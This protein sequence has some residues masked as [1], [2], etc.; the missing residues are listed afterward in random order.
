MSFALSAQHKDPEA[1]GELRKTLELKP[2][3]YEADLNLGILLLRNQRPAEA[4]SVLK[5]AAGAKPKEFR[6]NY[7]CGDALLATGD[8]EGAAHYYEA[9]GGADPKSAAAQLGLAHALLKAGKLAEAAPH[10]RAAAALDPQYRDG[11]LELAAA[12]E[13]SK[14]P[15][16]A[17]AIYREFPENVAARERMGALQVE[18]KDYTS[19][20]PN[21]EQ[22]VRTSPTPANRL[23]LADAYRM[24]GDHGKE[25]EQLQLAAAAEP[26]NFDL[27]MILGRALR[28]ERKLIPAAD[29]FA[30]ATRL[31]PDDVKAWNELAAAL[32]IGERYAEGLAALD[33]V[34]ALGKEL[35]GDFYLRAIT[36][37]KLQMKPQALA[38]YR[39][40]LAAD[41]GAA[42]DQEFLARQRI[43][44][45]ESEMKKR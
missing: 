13:K 45:I 6:P 14:Q 23:A 41:G 32:I 20:I 43:R 10:F 5:Q 3:L 39:Q 36:L 35:A 38:A 33:H 22:A 16:E 17:I 4:V 1:I 24:A 25:I 44:I 37:D 40:F 15:A 12:Y 30:A 9:A 8:A 18:A 26:D 42:P 29:E 2:G 21:L 7:Y 34:H 28:D 11:L 27:R 19:A 31:R